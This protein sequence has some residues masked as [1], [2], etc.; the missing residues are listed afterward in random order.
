LDDD[1]PDLVADEDSDEED[2]TAWNWREV[3]IKKAYEEERYGARLN[4]A[5]QRIYRHDIPKFQGGKS[6]PINFG[7][8]CLWC[9]C[10]G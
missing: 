10:L 9:L 3:E 1:L 8:S 7:T 4:E 2:D 6:G 5:P